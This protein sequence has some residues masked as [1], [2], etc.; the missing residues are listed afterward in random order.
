MPYRGQPNRPAYVVEIAHKLAAAI[1][2]TPEAV[3]RQ[4][5][6]NFFRLFAKAGRRAAD[7]AAAVA[8]APPPAAGS[9]G[10][11]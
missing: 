4:A 9:S 1:G 11:R 2:E 8:L 3:A 5:S 6:E 10:R 7:R